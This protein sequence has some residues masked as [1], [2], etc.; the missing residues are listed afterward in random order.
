MEQVKNNWEQIKEEG[1][2]LKNAA[3]LVFSVLFWGFLI[4]VG[5][6]AFLEAIFQITLTLFQ[7]FLIFA[8]VILFTIVKAWWLNR[9]T[10]LKK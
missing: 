9:Q 6:W 10:N 1:R 5:F 2:A 8:G 3:G 4:M 7:A